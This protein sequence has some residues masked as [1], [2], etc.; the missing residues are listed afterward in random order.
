[1]IEFEL[2]LLHQNQNWRRV[3][4]AYRTHQQRVKQTTPEMDGWLERVVRVDGVP[5]EQLP[6]VHGKLIALGLL[7]FQ[8]AGRTSGV[9]YQLSPEG[10]QALHSLAT[11]SE[12]GGDGLPELAQSA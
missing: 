1:M 8:L 2:E 3:L 10:W 4:E 7:K 9:R 11:Q 12:T 6:R 5:D